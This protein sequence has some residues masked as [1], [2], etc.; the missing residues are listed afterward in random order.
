MFQSAL[1]FSWGFSSL[2]HTSDERGL[3][4]V[5]KAPT[6]HRCIMCKLTARKSDGVKKLHIVSFVYLLCEVSFSAIKE[7]LNKM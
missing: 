3:F 4:A 5:Q 2:L 7:P 1:I 6:L